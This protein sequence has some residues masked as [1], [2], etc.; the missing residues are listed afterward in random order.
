MVKVEKQL[1]EKEK[2]LR[3]L[4]LIQ[5]QAELDK[6]K[7]RGLWDNIHA[8]RRRIASGIGD[9][10]RKKGEKGVPTA[11]QLKKAQGMNKGGVVKSAMHRGCG[12]V[13]PNKRKKTNYS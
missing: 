9:Q 12:A 4:S 1:K 6:I 7:K 10:M 5:V 8:K 2:Q 3:G 13:M 11:A